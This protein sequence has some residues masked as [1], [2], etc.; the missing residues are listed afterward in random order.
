MS[1]TASEILEGWIDPE[2]GA[3][4]PFMAEWI[5]QLREWKHKSRSEAPTESSHYNY[6]I[7]HCCRGIFEASKYLLTGASPEYARAV[8][9]AVIQELE[10]A[11]AFTS[12]ETAARQNIDDMV[13]KVRLGIVIQSID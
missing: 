7:Y 5:G 13:K 4:Y 9:E 1:Y 12:E 6:G 8:G 2:S 10:A 11:A 3:Y